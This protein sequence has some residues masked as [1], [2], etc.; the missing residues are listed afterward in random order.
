MK[1]SGLFN[2]FSDGGSFDF[3]RSTRCFLVLVATLAA[4]VVLI[5][6]A[7]SGVVTFS[8]VSPTSG[9]DKRIWANEN[10]NL[11]RAS[12]TAYKVALYWGPRG[13]REEQLVRVGSAASFLTGTAAG[14]FSGGHRTLSP[15]SENGG[16]AT[17][18]TRGWK[19]IPGIE[20]S[21][22][23]VLGAALAGDTRAFL[24][25]GPVFDHDTSRSGDPSD[26]V[27]PIGNDP[28]WNGF[29]IGGAPSYSLNAVG[30]YTVDTP[31][32]WYFA[33]NQLNY[34]NNLLDEVL[35]LP[36]SAEG[37][38]LRKWDAHDQRYLD[39]VDFVSGFGWYSPSDPA[40]ALHPGEGGLM[41]I[42]NNGAPA[43]LQ[44][45]FVGEIARRSC[46]TIYAG[47]NFRSL[48]LGGDL[49]EIDPRDGD[50]LFLFDTWQQQYR[51]TIYYIDGF[52][53]FDPS[54]A[55][56]TSGP[57]I[58]VGQSF[59]L[60]TSETRNPCAI[61]G[62]VPMTP[63]A[64]TTLMNPTRSGSS[65]S[66][67]FQS[68]AGKVYQMQ[69]TDTYPGQWNQRGVPIAGNGQ[70]LQFTDTTASVPSRYYRLI[71]Q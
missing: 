23:A 28:N 36:G 56:D 61:Q 30:Y 38:Y 52:G 34:K 9:D 71:I 4:P 13:A 26:P 41:F 18:Q 67:E 58:P 2:R 64:G 69:T 50:S 6:Q 29:V 66:F 15:I 16:V 70:V 14:M 7:P 59:F 20:D 27:Y 19:T 43:P 44:L 68:E 39:M 48:S 25:K 54:G 57:R 42:M 37:T 32:G 12:G 22:E 24:G 55:S 63:L 35:P 40:P 53:W 33:A 60:L 62:A 11:I 49:S 8:N 51:D 65:F 10:G 17:L 47:W 31:G 45:T 46:A 21:Y 1:T 5:A 3:P